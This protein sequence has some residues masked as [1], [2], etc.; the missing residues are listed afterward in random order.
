MHPYSTE[1]SRVSTYAAL[2]VVSVVVS[3]GVVAA[4]SALSWPQW[5]ISA[6]SLAA[7]FGLSYRVFDRWLWRLPF[8]HK[9]GMVG[10][11]LIAGTYKGRLISTFQDPQGNAIEKDITLKVSQTWTRISVEMTVSSGSSS[12]VST[13]AIGSVTADGS[14]TRLTYIYRNRVNPGVADAD[15]GDHDGAAQL[16]I[17]SDGRVSGR[18]FNSRPRAGTIE[19]TFVES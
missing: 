11:S 10:V 7:T 13:S 1:E 8:F 6:P 12:S 9:L 4:T 3:W 17:Y 18:Y 2:A 15:M 19:A 14:A 16:R 5:L